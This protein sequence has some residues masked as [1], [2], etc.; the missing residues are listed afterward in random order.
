MNNN[1]KRA[2]LL[3]TQ[4]HGNHSRAT[5]AAMLRHVLEP[6]AETR[7]DPAFVRID[8]EIEKTEA[9]IPDC[10][11][12]CCRIGL[13]QLDSEFRKFLSTTMVSLDDNISSHH[14]LADRRDCSSAPSYVLDQQNSSV[15]V[16][17]YRAD[18]RKKRPKVEAAASAERIDSRDR[19][20]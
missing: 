12:D 14:E 7:M 1:E 10:I 2:P 19:I 17:Y 16:E 5:A 8:T 18:T 6:P 3:K 13:T 11:A 15:T 4:N 20:E 9:V